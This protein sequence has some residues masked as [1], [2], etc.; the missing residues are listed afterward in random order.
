[1]DV[2][3]VDYNHN[4]VSPNAPISSIRRNQVHFQFWKLRGSNLLS[5]IIYMA[6]QSS[7]SHTA[8]V[9]KAVGDAKARLG[10]QD[11]YDNSKV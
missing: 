5:R 2:S 4:G 8:R 10:P 9:K 7:R 1:M 11:G 6:I 3:L